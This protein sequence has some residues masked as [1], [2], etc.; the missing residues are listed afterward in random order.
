ME[1]L[2]GTLPQTPDERRQLFLLKK[3]MVDL[4]LIEATIDENREIHIKV[5]IGAN[6]VSYKPDCC[7]FVA[8]GVIDQ[9]TS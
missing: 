7:D 4:F 1:A 8:A 9:F 3:K 5:R 6:D 2:N